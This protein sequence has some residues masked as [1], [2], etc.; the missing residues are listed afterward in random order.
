MSVVLWGVPF[1]LI[2]ALPSQAGTLVLLGMVGV[3]NALLDVAFFSLMGRLVADEVLARV[4]GVLESLIAA[5][6]GLGAIVTPIAIAALGIEGALIALGSICPLA[7][8]L[9]WPRLRALD[10]VVSV[11]EREI[12]LLRRVPMLGVLPVV[13][14]EQLARSARQVAA[15][16]GEV[17]CEQG[18]VA[19]AFFVIG[20]GEAVVTY[21]GAFVRTLGPGDGFGEIGLLRNERRS[22]TVQ[23]R[24]A[25]R[26][27]ELPG[28]VFVSIVS[29]YSAS[30]REAET[31]VESR[32]AHFRPEG[33]AA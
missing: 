21:D 17:L 1:A 24:T 31:V 9:S 29:G 2:G 4:Y 6:V 22:A 18:A 27:S 12:E 16:P 28:A 25:L 7:A 3:G 11:R 8:A 19:D 10:R 15:A 30:A 26:A 13:T 14:I 32:L 23:A 20:D 33:Y 5:A